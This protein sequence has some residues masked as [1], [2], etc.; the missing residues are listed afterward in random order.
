[1]EFSAAKGVTNTPWPPKLPKQDGEDGS[2]HG[3]AG[4]P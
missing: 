2:S 3:T 4:E 1:M